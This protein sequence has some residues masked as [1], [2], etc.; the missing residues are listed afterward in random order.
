MKVFHKSKQKQKL[1]DFR[2]NINIFLFF[3]ISQVL[4]VTL[5]ICL[6]GPPRLGT[7]VLTKTKWI[8]KLH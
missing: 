6:G 8:P 7:T 2:K 1:Q 4:I 5:G 3:L